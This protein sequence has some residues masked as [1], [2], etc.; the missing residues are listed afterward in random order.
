MNFKNEFVAHSKIYFPDVATVKTDGTK[1]DIIDLRAAENAIVKN[2]IDK[3]HRQKSTLSEIAIVKRAAFKFFII[4]V[5]FAVNDGVILEFCEIF[6][7]WLGLSGKETKF[8]NMHHNRIF[9][10]SAFDFLKPLIFPKTFC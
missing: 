3:G 1:R 7:H 4:H 6:G 8:R 9:Y 10:F 5:V 2:T